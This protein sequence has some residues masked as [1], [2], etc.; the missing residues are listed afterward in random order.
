MRGFWRNKKALTWLFELRLGEGL[1]IK[2]KL[3]IMCF[4][5]N[6]HPPYV[7]YFNHL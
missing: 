4:S 5:E 1:D 3:L 7:L 2:L 6:G